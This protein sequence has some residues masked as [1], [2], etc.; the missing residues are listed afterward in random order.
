MSQDR[1][2]QF[3]SSRDSQGTWPEFDWSEPVAALARYV[4]PQSLRRLRLLPDNIADVFNSDPNDSV[5]FLDTL[6]QLFDTLHSK[7]IEYAHEPWAGRIGRQLIRD[8]RWLLE[9]R[10]GTCLDLAVTFAAQCLEARLR[11]LLALSSTHAF[12]IAARAATL[13]NPG[14]LWNPLEA[15]DFVAG[16]REL[17]EGELRNRIDDDEFIVIDVV[18]VTSASGTLETAQAN[19][20][21]HLSPDL[22]L[23]DVAYLH[24]N[25]RWA[26]LDPPLTRPT[27]HPYVPGGQGTFFN[28]TNHRDLIEA[29]ERDDGVVVLIG[30]AGQGKSSIARKL[31]IEAPFE[32]GWFLNAADPQALMTGLADADLAGENETAVAFDNRDREG[33]YLRGLERLRDAQGRWVVVLD[34]ADGDPGRL[35]NLVPKP[36]DGQLVIVTTTN[37]EW[38]RVPG[39]LVR[40]LQPIDDEQVASV[41]GS[42]E[43]VMLVAGRAL[44][45]DGFSRLLRSTGL[46]AVYVAERLGQVG[47]LPEEL[48]GPMALWLSLSHYLE[49]SDE[50]LCLCLEMAYLPPDY[51]SVEVLRTLH[52][53]PDG[54]IGRLADGG[55]IAM[56][57]SNN[58][59]RL[60]R[61]YSEVIRRHLGGERPDLDRA[62]VLNV[63]KSNGAAELVDRYGGWEVAARLTARLKEIDANSIEPEERLGIALHDLAAT[64]ELQGH[65]RESADLYKLSERHVPDRKDLLADSLHGRARMVNQHHAKDEELLRQALGWAREA[66]SIFMSM[67]GLESSADR[68]LAMQG[69]IEQKLANFPKEGETTRELLLLA[70]STIERAHEL[71]AARL[72][73]HDPELARSEFNLAGPRIRLAQEDR[74]HSQLHLDAAEVIYKVVLGRRREIYAREV[75]PHIAAC[76][77]GLGF[78]YYYRAMLLGAQPSDRDRWLRTA[79]THTLDALR[80][81][82][83]LDGSLDLDESKK[84]ARFLAKVAAARS[85][86]PSTP[87]TTVDGLAREVGRELS[88]AAAP[89]LPSNARNASEAIAAWTD[90]SALRRVVLAFGG[91]IPEIKGPIEGEE[92]AERLAWLEEFSEQ[93]DFRGGKER[94]LVEA[95]DF[96][97]EVQE[98][99]VQAAAALGLIGT[100]PPPSV[101]Y[102]YIL[103]LGGLVRAC[104]ARPLHAARL[105]N[106]GTVEPGEV[107]ALGGYRPLAGNELELATSAGHP[108]LTDEFEAM[109]VG[110]R[111]AFSLDD[112]ITEQGE[113]SE[114][115]GASWRVRTYSGERGTAIK[116]IAAPSS[117]PGVRR[118]NTPDTYQWFASQLADLRGGERILVVTSDIYVPFQHADALRM[119]SLPYSVEVDMVGIQPGDVD[120]SLAQSFGTHNYLQEIRS[121][122]RSF[123]ALHDA[124]SAET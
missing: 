85:A 39:V 95:G 123:R 38:E 57:P 21:H 9:D 26:P 33:F 105:L 15:A 42:S 5:V 107:C 82:E 1:G 34:N 22:V 111:A 27:L 113:A 76:I 87:G 52:S 108:G 118:A 46:L 93:W 117:E 23:V 94:N 91:A 28:Y 68:C 102:D 36:G 32:A 115:E 65:T 86:S 61:L 63:V 17:G 62:A 49:L 6:Q 120:P 8:P 99:V 19:G 112:P 122:F 84:V 121:A 71:R 53:D 97:P 59:M 40:R 31:A 81:R 3:E 56:N 78:V 25:A 101:Q 100:A 114:I 29:L 45:V 54:L 110:V 69:L 35:T 80:Q 43:L 72:G 103:I 75:H 124:L 50:D 70:L 119:L 41:L 116:V 96:S 24:Q 60:H 98:F 16:V 106:D 13:N 4:S 2:D 37:R 55:L 66:Q 10:W 77:I 47:R 12:V 44:M 88:F 73:P 48:R 30:P 58:S 18:E 20:R 14:F 11:P 51:P 83:L 92:L 79:T 67:P 7:D 89:T 90:S 74:A 64:L 109:D 104:L